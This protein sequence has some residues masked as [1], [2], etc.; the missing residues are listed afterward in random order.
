MKLNLRVYGV[1]VSS[2]FIWSRT[3]TSGWFLRQRSIIARKDIVMNILTNQT[4]LFFK[5][6]AASCSFTL[7]NI[8]PS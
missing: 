4:V 6:A 3:E 7:R 5:K 2:G 1:R 8:S